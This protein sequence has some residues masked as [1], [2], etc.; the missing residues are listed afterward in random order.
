MVSNAV[1]SAA[2]LAFEGFD[3]DQERSSNNHN[4]G[5]RMLHLQTLCNDSHQ[6]KGL[7]SGIVSVW[8]IGESARES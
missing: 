1:V 7:E 6:A 5:C 2:A 4:H 8:R 3:V